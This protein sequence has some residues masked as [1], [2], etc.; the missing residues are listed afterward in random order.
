MDFTDMN[1][2]CLKDSFPLPKIDM[3]VGAFFGHNQIKLSKFDHEKIAFIIEYGYEERN[4]ANPNH[5]K[6]INNILS[7]L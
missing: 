6:A 5:I 4:E 7:P 2:A 3:L 1:K